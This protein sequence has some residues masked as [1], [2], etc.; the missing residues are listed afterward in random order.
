MKNSIAHT[1]TEDFVLFEQFTYLAR[2]CIQI[3][4]GNSLDSEWAF[5]LHG[6]WGGERISIC[7]TD[8]THTGVWNKMIDACR[9][10]INDIKKDCGANN[11]V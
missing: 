5:K 6:Y 7:V 2:C 10:Y 4:R 3:G 9:P 1:E 11:A 8:A